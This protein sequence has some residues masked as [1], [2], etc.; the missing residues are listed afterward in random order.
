MRV[1]LSTSAVCWSGFAR[2]KESKGARASPRP[3]AS[4]GG[5]HSCADKTVGNSTTESTNGVT[6]RGL[7]PS[8]HPTDILPAI[9]VGGYGCTARLPNRGRL[10]NSYLV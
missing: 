4:D 6:K 5:V 10:F 2:G 3:G 1:R 8:T 9:S 7:T